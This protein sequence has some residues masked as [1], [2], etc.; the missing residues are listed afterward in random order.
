MDDV[1]VFRM[2]FIA[3]LT[4]GHAKEEAR[5]RELRPAEWTYLSDADRV[6]GFSP[7]CPLVLAD[8][9]H[10]RPDAER[11]AEELRAWKGWDTPETEVDAPN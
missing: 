10:L 7:D 6:R 9:F 3:A 8:S 2:T 11:M 1:P 5:Q 4:L